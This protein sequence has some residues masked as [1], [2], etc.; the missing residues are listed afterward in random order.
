MILDDLREFVVQNEIT[1]E[2]I[3]KY[4]YDSFNIFNLGYGIKYY[5][6]E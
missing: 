5:K 2:D 3:I 4:D 1:P 6:S